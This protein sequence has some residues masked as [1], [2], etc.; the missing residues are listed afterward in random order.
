[1]N[2]WGISD[3][4][5]Q[6]QSAALRK[7][8]GVACGDAGPSLFFGGEH[9]NLPARLTR[10]AKA[11]AVC[12]GCPAR[13]PCL[14][15]AVGAGEIFGVWGGVDLEHGDRMCGTGEHL[16]DAANTYVDPDGHRNC[17]ACRAE[18]DQRANA[19]RRAA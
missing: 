11:K 14:E 3:H 7:V 2:E 10:V 9:E 6:Q 16:M 5:M 18:A 8:S 4:L 17:R 12:A 19:R 15:Y 1:M 13:V